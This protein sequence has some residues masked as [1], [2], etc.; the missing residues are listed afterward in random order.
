VTAEH[1]LHCHQTVSLHLLTLYNATKHSYVPPEFCIG[2][3]IPLLKDS[4]LDSSNFDNYRAITISPVLSKIFENCLLSR[5]N[6]Y[7]E[8]SDLQC[9]FKAK[10]GCSEALSLL[11]STVQYFTNNGST[12]SIASL[13]MSKAF[14]KVNHYAL[15]LKLK[16]RNVPVCL[17]NL[18]ANWY[19]NVFIS[20]KWGQSLLLVFVKVGYFL[21]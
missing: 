1:V 3:T 8:T 16:E 5:F 19:K 11:C 4:N 13:D 20:V 10:A 21:L 12:V 7:F 18:L 17:I 6:C 14:D 15:F 9:G 2:I